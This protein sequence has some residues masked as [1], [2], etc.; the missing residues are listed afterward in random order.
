MAKFRVIVDNHVVTDARRGIEDRGMAPHPEKGLLGNVFGGR[1]V[2][3]DGQ[4]DTEDPT[5]VAPYER[6]TGPLVARGHPSHQR[7]VGGAG[8]VG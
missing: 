7:L 2:H 5:L 1:P 4:G 6:R 3:G 8:R